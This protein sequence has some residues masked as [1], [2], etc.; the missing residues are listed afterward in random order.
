MSE[1]WPPT[2]EAPE[3]EGPPVDASKSEPIEAA[4]AEPASASE[5]APGVPAF[6]QATPAEGTPSSPAATT[7]PGEVPFSGPPTLSDQHP[8][9]QYGSPPA[10]PPPYP[11]QAYPSAG[12]YPPSGHY[13]QGA[14]PAPGHYP[15]GAPLPPGGGW[16]T[17]AA[18][19]WGATPP[20]G[21]PPP[22]GGWGGVP[23]APVGWPHPGYGP[24]TTPTRPST[25]KTVAAVT[26]ALLLVVAILAGAGV[27]HL[28]WSNQSASNPGAFTPNGSGS[29]G[30][31]GSS[32]F[33]GGS[34]GSGSSGSTGNSSTG[35]GA[36]S[37]ISSIASKVDPGIVDINTNLSYQNEQ[38]AGTGQV[39]TSNGEVLTN[40]HVIDGATSISVTDVGNGK[41][42]TAS[43]VGYDRTA[44]V[45]VLKLQGASGLQ[46]VTTSD[47]SPA[48]GQAIVGIGNAGGAGGTPSTA[49]GSIIALAQSIT[50][51]DSGGANAENLSGLIEINAPIQPGDSGGPLVNTSSQ[52]IGMDT[53]AAETSGFDTTGNQAYA[54]PITTA[55]S[56]A[57][58]IGAGKSSSTIHI[59]QTAFLGVEIQ[60]SSSNSSNSGGFGGFG[61]GNGNGNG[62]GGSSTTSGAVVAGT[63]SGGAAAQAGLAQGDVI[64]EFNG[65][66]INTPDDLSNLM[67]GEHPGDSVQLQWTDQSGQTHSASITLGSG[68]PT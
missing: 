65:H 41:T 27:G 48:V 5:T 61:V 46:T 29:T 37:D 63:V 35:A 23:G 55:L 38:A 62:N 24:S 32:P 20:P 60:P 21:S 4:P 67:A 42:Y 36:P 13:P 9:Q 39:L 12:Q 58:Q 8:T 43:V 45:A 18:A 1:S 16:T 7:A 22:P 54:I 64:T 57:H 49:G 19:P 3:A 53:A 10:A 47:Q 2:D 34:T 26:A 33:G 59:G 28:V 15:S 25:R 52:V 66:T 14:Y 6:P 68:P 44:D 40:N 51:S 31:G 11:P 30:N 17:P 56:I 50:A